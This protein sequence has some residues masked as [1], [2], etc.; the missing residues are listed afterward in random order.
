LQFDNGDLICQQVVNPQKETQ[1]KVMED[2]IQQSEV[3]VPGNGENE[4]LTSTLV[5]E[6]LRF[7]S[8][9]ALLLV[10]SGTVV[11]ASLLCSPHLW[12]GGFGFKS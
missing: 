5:A 2:T 7:E 6:G 11:V 3:N 9:D 12:Q 10:L 4:R 1:N 8:W